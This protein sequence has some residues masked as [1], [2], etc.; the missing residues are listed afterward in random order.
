MLGRPEDNR[1]AFPHIVGTESLAA[2]AQDKWAE[3][4][5]L[6]YAGHLL[7]RF[8]LVLKRD[9]K[10][11]MPAQFGAMKEALFAE[12]IEG[13]EEAMG[14]AFVNDLEE[15]RRGM[16]TLESCAGLFLEQFKQ[17]GLSAQTLERETIEGLVQVG[18]GL[19]RIRVLCAHPEHP[20]RV[21]DWTG[22]TEPLVLFENFPCDAPA[23]VFMAGEGE[24][25]F[26]KTFPH[27]CTKEFPLKPLIP[28]PS[29]SGGA[30][31]ENPK[32]SI[33]TAEGE[34]HVLSRSLS[35]ASAL[36]RLLLLYGTT[37]QDCAVIAKETGV[38]GLGIEGW[39]V[40]LRES[41]C[42]EDI[43]KLLGFLEEC[44]QEEEVREISPFLQSFLEKEEQRLREASDFRGLSEVL[45]L[46]QRHESG[47]AK[48]ISLQKAANVFRE[49]LGD[50]DAAFI[51]LSTALDAMPTYDE[52]LVVDLVEVAKQTGKEDEVVEKLLKIAEAGRDAEVAVRAGTLA[53]GEKAKL[54]WRLAVRAENATVGVL[55]DALAFA[56][57]SGDI[58]LM[59]E[60]CEKLRV[61]AFDKEKK[62]NATMML[63]AIISSDD[64]FGAAKLLEEVLQV[65]PD[66]KEALDAVLE[67]YLKTGKPEEGRRVL[68]AVLGRTLVPDVRTYCLKR[69]VPLLLDVFKEHENAL[70]YLEEYVALSPDDAPALGLLE[71]LYEQAQMWQ[72]YLMLLQR[73]ALRDRGNAVHYYLA[74]A[75]CAKTRLGDEDMYA[76]FLS[77]AL[78]LDPTDRV[79]RL[80]M[81]DVLE[82][83][84]FFADVIKFLEE[85]AKEAEGDAVCDV[86]LRMAEVYQGHLKRRDKA[87][88]VLGKA[89]SVAGSAKVVAIAS[90]LATLHEED[91]EIDEARKV[92]EKTLA[93]SIEDEKKVFVLKNLVR[94]SSAMVALKR[95]Y[96]EA[97]LSLN[98]LEKEPALELARLYVD[99]LE[100]EKV[101]ALLDPLVD[102]FKD[103][104]SFLGEA[105]ELCARAAS[106]LKMSDVAL[107]HLK[108]LLELRP[109]DARLTVLTIKALQEASNHEEALLK[110][111]ELLKKELR[112]SERLE[113]L[114]LA[115]ESC[116]ATQR[117]V[118]ALEY[119]EA[120][121]ALEGKRDFD[122][123]MELVSLA[124]KAQDKGRLVRYL[125]EA[126]GKA[127]DA[128][129]RYAIKMRLGELFRESGEH[130][131]ALRWFMDALNEGVSSKVALFNALQEAEEVQD[132]DTMAQVLQ[133][134]IEIEMDCQKRARLKY[135]LA[136]HEMK[137]GA[138][139]KAKELLW[140]AI[141]DDIGFEEARKALENIL[142]ADYDSDGL[143]ELYETLLKQARASGATERVVA[144]L[145]KLLD[146][147]E[148][149]MKNPEQA[150][151]VITQ[152][153]EIKGD[154]K[155]LLIRLAKIS[156]DT[157]GMEKVMLD[158]HRRMLA[159]DPTHED[160]YKAIRNIFS[161]LK[162]E[163]GLWCAS[164]A[165]LALGLGG[166]EDKAHYEKAREPALRL[167]RD[168][169]SKADFDKLIRDKDANCEV[170]T[171]FHILYQPLLRLLSWKKPAD[172]GLGEQDVIVPRGKSL[173]EN[174]ALAVSK[175]LGVPLPK[176]YRAKGRL[177]VAKLAF[178]PPALALG[179][180]C[181]EQW[182]GKEIR[183][184][185]GRALVSFMPGFEMA[186]IAADAATL[187]LF[188][189]AALKVVMPDFAVPEDVSGVVELASEL[190]ALLDEESK[191]Q[192]KNSID[193]F[194]QSKR[195]IDIVAFLEGI[196]K[197]ASRAGFF[198]CNDILVAAQVLHDDQLFLSDLEYGDKLLDMCAYSVSERYFELR[199]QM[200]KGK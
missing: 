120:I 31:F 131:G 37:A 150:M 161:A 157:L 151:S 47:N 163:E 126:L 41:V 72:K 48:V 27:L 199:R 193:A 45:V 42:L 165:L 177:G 26:S 69:L 95:Q 180:D 54:A 80:K 83:R 166:D 105:L 24:Q 111:E 35:S 52:A 29:I 19:N 187:K 174:M 184:A 171:V 61:L 88:E 137:R 32:G 1:F 11:A 89:F 10:V 16:E 153:L 34:R 77:R 8:V 156:G 132:L 46:R 4:S 76:V 190:K 143:V 5:L 84:G 20:E 65:A 7:A 15:I 141:K 9:A 140:S 130:Y 90:R 75:D 147:Y 38:Y 81:R 100:F 60:A 86:Y 56:K 73:K 154:D 118:K 136:M 178:N 113:V 122:T 123:M 64:P 98:P 155:D 21:W 99:A 183:F 25:G 117:D 109:E 127:L 57:E 128:Q 58:E 179:D 175:I 28:F 96:L 182:R 194:R 169:V 43:E 97:I 142:T 68:E 74:M 30:L 195:P 125:M 6:L 12:V 85:E 71:G 23:T 104:K 170:A 116:V 39:L 93:H 106:A 134:L 129:S 62:L 49:R 63:A 115:K 144:L 135:P 22:R 59:K 50:N 78:D 164:G 176:L 2:S 36:A 114:R 103:D 160:S 101:L 91:G 158:A 108:A 145:E 159:I 53:K 149:T 133:K 124:D 188:F 173:F 13:E 40:K 87:K 146:L 94:L 121:L 107:G 152:I 33:F 148:K 51:C 44:G 18:R 197:T 172:V 139:A 66:N 17:G 112:A 119:K 198:L 162:D 67:I 189:L 192:L 191:K 102:R 200:L 70:A 55:D 82:S 186:G 79:L 92:W 185:M 14:G 181:L 167:K 3:Q 110:C 196:D 168:L 138:K